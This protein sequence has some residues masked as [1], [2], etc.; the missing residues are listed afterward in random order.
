MN[1]RKRS[2]RLRS[3]LLLLVAVGVFG[4]VGWPRVRQAI[5]AR[6]ALRAEVPSPD[7]LQAALDGAAD[8]GDF[9]DRLWQTCKVPQ[10]EW[11]IS[12]LGEEVA[13]AASLS[14]R[15]AAI[16]RAGALD[17]DLNVREQ[18]LSLLAA[19]ND[20]EF[21]RLAAAQLGDVDPEIRLLGLRLIR[22]CEARQAL[23]AVIPLLED[24]DLRVVAS[25]ETALR[26]WTGID[27]GVRLFH[28][29]AP[30]EGKNATD[31]DPAATVRNAVAQRLAWW[32][33]HRSEYTATGLTALTNVSRPLPVDALS[34]FALEDL[35]GRAVRLSEFRGRPVLLNF[36]A[37]WCTACAAELPDLIQLA[38]RRP[39]EVV[40][41]GISLDGVPDE[42]GHDPGASDA[43]EHISAGGTPSA[44]SPAV[45][46]AR[47]RVKRFAQAHGI[48]YLVLLDPHNQVGARFNGGELPTNVLL[49]GAG[50]LRRRFIGGRSAAVLEAMIA[51][52][53]PGVPAAATDPKRPR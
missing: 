18:A 51:E 42:H 5:T 14:A 26:G 19:K 53:R 29:L 35:D 40:V 13:T 49:D 33:E 21:C 34:D 44:D 7:A 6:L 24:P 37:T 17:A 36:W 9:L 50:R 41:I 16:L 31:P 10:R 30:G 23:P 15:Q 22:H 46:S 20:A 27:Y 28:V 52:L 48:N 8:P 39:E 3:L 47:A 43:G 4:V 38:K 1:V 2:T 32:R 25:A 11:A 12:R 45:A